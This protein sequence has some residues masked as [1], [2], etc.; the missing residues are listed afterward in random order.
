MAQTIR[1]GPLG[2]ARTF[3]R[4]TARR[5]GAE[6]DATRRLPCMRRP[7]T[8]VMGREG[9]QSLLLPETPAGESID[10]LLEQAGG[11]G[12]CQWLTTAFG[13]YLW[14]VHGGQVM[15]FVYIGPAVEAEFAGEAGSDEERWLLRLSGSFFFAGW[16]AGLGLWG[17]LGTRHGWL[18]SLACMESLVVLGGCLTAMCSGPRSY[19]LCRVAV[20]FAEGGVPTAAWGYASEF[21]LPSKKAQSITA[22]QLGFIFGLLMLALAS[23]ADSWRAQTFGAALFAL[24]IP[25]VA[26]YYLPESPRWLLRAGKLEE[27]RAVLR[28]IAATNRVDGLKLGSMELSEPA[29]D[30]PRPPGSALSLFTSGPAVRRVTLIVT[31][32]AFAYTSAYFGLSLH[33]VSV[34]NKGG[35]ST[36]DGLV[37][38]LMQVP[39]VFVAASMLEVLGR[40]RSLMALLGIL[41]A[42]CAAMA[43]LNT[44]A[45]SQHHAHA[46]QLNA[47]LATLGC[48][49]SNGMFSVMYVFSSEVFPT[50]VRPVGLA[51]KSQAARVGAFCAP[52]VLLL[53]DTDPRL[54]FAFWAVF[55]SIACLS[56][57]WLPETLGQ[58]SLESLEDLS[59]LVARMRSPALPKPLEDDGA[60]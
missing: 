37:S 25:F 54:P 47:T 27:C 48:M 10:S 28:F 41:A 36:S 40:R 52:L 58:P 15:A 53:S 50:A 35:G 3:Q 16:I 6:D 30:G 26:R 51:T 2:N 60:L 59:V 4:D 7:H 31:L 42:S 33:L 11:H 12:R 38:L 24:P 49:V 55:A 5:N 18:V 34:S 19:L 20:G 39:V 56:S 9:T 29:T 17:W 46:A 32:Q 21:L 45:R 23:S 43:L 8:A 14:A 1:R 22:L 13:V 57:L 44:P